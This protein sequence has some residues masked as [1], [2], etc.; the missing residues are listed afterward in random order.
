MREARK[1]SMQ[2]QIFKNIEHSTFNIEHPMI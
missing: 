1:G 2:Q